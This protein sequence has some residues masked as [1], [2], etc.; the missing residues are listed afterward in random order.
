M[1]KSGFLTN[2]GI[3][4]ILAD[5][6]IVMAIL[7]AAAC[8]FIFVSCS[9]SDTDSGNDPGKTQEGDLVESAF[10]VFDTFKNTTP[11]YTPTEGFD[12]EPEGVTYG[13]TYGKVTV[14][15][16]RSFS[17]GNDTTGVM[18]RVSIY[19]PPGY[20]P[21]T[22]YPVLFLLHGIGGDHT[23]WVNGYAQGDGYYAHLNEIMSNLII[24]DKAKPMIVVVP[25][26]RA[27]IPDNAPSDLTGQTNVN[28]FLNFPNDLKNDLIPYI[29]ENYIVSE[30]RD[31]WA[32]AGLSMGGA[33]TMNIILDEFGYKTFG[34]FGAFSSA[35]FLMK[36]ISEFP[37]DYK[38][39]TFVMLCSGTDDSAINSV[40]QFRDDFKAIGVE[41]AYYELPG[42][43][44][45][46]YV[47]NNALY[48]FAQ[49][50]FKE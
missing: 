6:L 49:C 39:N 45:G 19:T 25:N 4:A 31:Q 30:E 44:H 2:N 22:A 41:P 36:P 40:I 33:V 14:R 48:H 3:L 42:G 23:E 17:T 10:K 15:E 26:V 34:Y 50:I 1:K 43:K 29:K 8:A 13:V 47:W 7:A 11:P 27:M 37:N 21:G 46:F 9:E 38:K 20:D 12:V 28:A 32:I 18:R 24:E 35:N 5:A 16:Y